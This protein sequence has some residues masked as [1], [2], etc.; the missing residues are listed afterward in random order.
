MDLFEILR[1][2]NTCRFYKEDPVDDETLARVLSAAR[3]APTGGNR[4]PVNLVVT[5]NHEKKL[6]LQK[7]YLPLWNE[8]TVGI[9]DGS[10]KVGTKDKRIVDNADYFAN[11][12]ANIP[13]LVTVCARLEDVHPTDV[14][15][16]RLSIVGGASV[17][18]AVQNI[19]LAARQNGLGSALTT[20]LCA[21]ESRVK[22]LLQIPEHVSTAAMLALGWPEKDF[23]SKLTRKPLSEIAWLESFGMPF[24]REE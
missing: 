4:Q 19:L 24:A 11:N 12:L 7:L 5:K 15:L 16:E 6:E 2:T 10:V 1:S 22:E 17:Y 23:P 21:V 13:V 20:L 14:N 18:P 3:W 8:Y 9:R